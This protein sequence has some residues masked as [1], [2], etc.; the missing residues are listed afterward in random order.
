MTTTQPDTVET[1]LDELRSVRNAALARRYLG[2]STLLD[3]R[4]DLEGISAMADHFRDA[5]RWSA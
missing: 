5:A 2:T 4:R 3:A 1:R